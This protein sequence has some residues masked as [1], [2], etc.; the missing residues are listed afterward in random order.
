MFAAPGVTAAILGVQISRLQHHLLVVNRRLG[1]SRRS[2]YVMLMDDLSICF[3]DKREFEHILVKAPSFGTESS[4]Y[5]IYMISI[6]IWLV[7]SNIFYFPFS[8]WV[9]ILPID[10]VHHFSEGLKPP[11]RY[12]FWINHY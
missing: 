6:Y 9:V 7:V 11:T 8:I 12:D 10:E 3:E 2:C 1:H 5:T 4:L